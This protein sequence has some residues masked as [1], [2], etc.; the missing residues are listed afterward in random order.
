[1]L[2]A[3]G[4]RAAEIAL[5]GGPTSGA[6]GSA[7]SDLAFATRTAAA[8]HVSYGLR[9]TLVFAATP[10]NA[11]ALLATDANLRRTVHEDLV[12]LQARAVDLARRNRSVVQAVADALVSGRVL[13]GRVSAGGGGLAVGRRGDGVSWRTRA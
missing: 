2:V 6:G 10:E 5:L 7:D 4:G 9:D 13:K 12:R 8:L 3:L 11:A 1:M